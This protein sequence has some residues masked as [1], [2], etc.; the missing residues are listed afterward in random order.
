MSSLCRTREAA[1]ACR[2]KD[3]ACSGT[4]ARRATEGRFV[5]LKRTILGAQ[6][7]PHRAAAAN[8]TRQRRCPRS[9]DPRMMQV[10]SF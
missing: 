8:G 3:L 2:A 7:A 10:G 6:R 9:H 5:R 4:S 1:A